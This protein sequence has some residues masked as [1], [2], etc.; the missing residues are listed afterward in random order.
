MEEILVAILQFL[1]EAI[2]NI[3]SFLP[4]DS[5]T[6]KRRELSYNAG[7]ALGWLVVGGVF[8]GLSLLLLSHTMIHRPDARIANVVITPLCSGGFAFLRSALRSKKDPLV[9]PRDHFW[10]AFWF[11]LAFALVRFA[12]AGRS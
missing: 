9:T 1:F 12:Y 4:I 3:G 5:A 2:I 7:T 11:S 10:F 8:G 6:S